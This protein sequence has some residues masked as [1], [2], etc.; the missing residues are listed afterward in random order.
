MNEHILS[1][2][3]YDSS[4]QFRINRH[5]RFSTRSRKIPRSPITFSLQSSYCSPF[6]I[7]LDILAI[8]TNIG[9]DSNNF[10]FHESQISSSIS[11]T[12]VNESTLAADFFWKKDSSISYWNE[13][14]IL[15]FLG[16]HPLIP[17]PDI[18][19]LM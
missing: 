8:F 4:G 19:L 9:S 10:K 12:L 18:V 1:M 13:R 17:Y 15:L 14:S 3:S 16:Y 6:Q 5:E 11:V 7:S 2:F